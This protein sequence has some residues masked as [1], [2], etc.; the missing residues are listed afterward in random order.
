MLYGLRSLRRYR[1]EPLIAANGLGFVLITDGIYR[2]DKMS[3]V[4]ELKWE[5][6]VSECRAHECRLMRAME[7]INRLLPLD[8]DVIE[9]LS[10]EQHAWLDHYLYRFAKLQDAMGERLFL[11]GLSLLGEEYGDQP[12][13]DALNRLEALNLIPSREWWQQ[14]REFRN[15]IAHEYPD[16]RAEQCAATNAIC[17]EGDTILRVLNGVIDTVEKKRAGA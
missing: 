13:I 8:T 9:A 10:D 7:D 12:F 3:S 11:S 2:I 5:S 15:Q 6:A 17:S 4:A 14:Q 1:C 16:R